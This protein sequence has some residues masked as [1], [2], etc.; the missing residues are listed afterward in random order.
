MNQLRSPFNFVL[1][2]TNF[3]AA[4]RHLQNMTPVLFYRELQTSWL[5]MIRQ[6][7]GL[8]FELFYSAGLTNNCKISLVTMPPMRTNELFFKAASKRSRH[9]IENKTAANEGEVGEGIKMLGVIKMECPILFSAHS[10]LHF[11]FRSV[12]AKQLALTCDWGTMTEL[13][14]PYKA[15]K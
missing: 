13:K 5:D 11:W 8:S 10:P 7:R 9:H 6:L 4:A 12:T 14:C 15:E 2:A 3:D 1:C